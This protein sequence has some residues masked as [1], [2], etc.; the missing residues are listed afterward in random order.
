M[1]FNCSTWASVLLHKAPTFSTVKC[2]V[3]T[4]MWLLSVRCSQFS[5]FKNRNLLFFLPSIVYYINILQQIVSIFVSF[6]T[7]LSE[8]YTKDVLTKE[9]FYWFIFL[10]FYMNISFSYFVE[11]IWCT[12]YFVVRKNLLQVGFNS[13]RA[14]KASIICM[15]K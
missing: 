10:I 1:K 9:F 15:V 11:W 7:I 2:W 6:L 4:H 14:V 8:F 5:I 13:Y 3:A 12:G